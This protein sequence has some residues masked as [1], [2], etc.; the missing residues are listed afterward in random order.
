ML[1]LGASPRLTA[2][3]FR[4]AREYRAVPDNQESGSRATVPGIRS[5]LFP[6]LKLFRARRTSEKMMSL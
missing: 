4:Q 1:D 6:E 5:R 2:V 3:R